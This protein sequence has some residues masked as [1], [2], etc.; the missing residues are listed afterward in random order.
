[1]RSAAR[2]LLP[3]TF[4]EVWKRRE[5]YVREKRTVIWH[6]DEKTVKAEVSG[7]EQYRIELKFSGGGISKKCNC[8]YARDSKTHHPACKH[9]VA[10]AIVW[11][12]LHDISPPTTEEIE[13]N[14]I[15]P[16]LV[17]R[18]QIDALYKDPLSA[19]LEVLRIAGEESGSWS[20]PHSRLGS[21]KYF[22]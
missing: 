3:K 13:A 2:L 14:A 16:P 19:D 11:D 20:R 18:A 7:T 22:V 1:M 21:V 12:G 9:M 15:P 8:P 4:I 6:A 5:K 17:S 10:V